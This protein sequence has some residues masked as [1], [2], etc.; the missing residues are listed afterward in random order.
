MT[1][2]SMTPTNATP[3]K[4]ITDNAN[5]MRRW[6]SK[7]SMPATS[8]KDR[9][10]AI[11]TAPSKAFGRSLSKRGAQISSSAMTR[12]PTRPVSWVRDPADSATGVRDELALTENP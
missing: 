2:P 11:T 6:R 5:S 1:M 9:Q 12:A 7:L 3:R 10:A 4:L 8:A